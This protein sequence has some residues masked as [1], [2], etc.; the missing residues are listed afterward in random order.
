MSPSPKRVR[1]SL[2][3]SKSTPPF[4]QT[5][6]K[7][8]EGIPKTPQTKVFTQSKSFDANSPLDT[9]RNK[10]SESVPVKVVSHELKDFEFRNDTL[11]KI[12]E[13]SKEI[14]MCLYPALTCCVEPYYQ[15]SMLVRG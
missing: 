15:W 10:V 5:D 7:T 12:V 1:F 8:M 3:R 11:R 4:V 14:K 6:F 13:S 2:D 9:C